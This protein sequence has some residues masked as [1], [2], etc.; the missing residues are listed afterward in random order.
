[1]MVMRRR[2]LVIVV[3]ALLAAAACSS[4]SKSSG[5]SNQPGTS[6][7]ASDLAKQCPLDALASAPKPVNITYWHAMTRANE[8]TLKKL[9]NQF[10]SS[11]TDVHVTLVNQQ[12]YDDNFTKYRTVAG[13]KDAPDLIQIE[14]TALQVMIDSNS[15]VPAAACVA[16]SHADMS[17]IL[18]RVLAYYSV[19]NTLYPVP[20][21][22]SNPVLYYNKV[23]FRKAG[24]DPDTPPA[25]LADVAADAAKIKASG[26]PYGFYY[27]RD[28]WVLEQFLALNGDPY[29]NNGNGRQSRATN[30]LFDTPASQALLTQIDQMVQS[31]VAATNPASGPSELDNVLA[32]CNGKA[33]MTIDTSAVLGTAYSV[34]AAGG[35]PAKIEVGVAPLPGA[36]PDGGVLVGG[37]ANYIPK[38]SDPAKIAAAWKFAQFLTTPASQATWSAG[39]GYL[40][41]SKQAATSPTL[42]AV[43]NAKPGYKVAYE[44]LVD[45]ATN[46]ATAGP[47]IGDYT[48]VRKTVTDMLEAILI[49]HQAVDS[50]L[51]NAAKQADGVIKDYNDTVG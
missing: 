19:G 22:V 25:T 42:T 48:G 28:S 2:G 9:T 31:G 17:D 44:Q 37:A 8:D 13:T 39:T 38:G 3:V 50:A 1:M 23:A 29:V 7:P 49:E 11:Q 41:I 34:L 24:L 4:S 33:A 12:G 40:P 32:L 6:A 45:G 27:K 20:F 5:G 16:A 51:T 14:D 36:K 18:P 30:V 47:V 10:N 35:C 15:I 26:Y 43:W 21:N 46:E